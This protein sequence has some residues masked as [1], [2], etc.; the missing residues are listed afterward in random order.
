MKKLKFVRETSRASITDG[1][2]L[3]GYLELG[4]KNTS[5]MVAELE[6]YKDTV[7]GLETE[8]KTL[9]LE[10]QYYRKQN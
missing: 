10:L 3:A 9:D 6:Y 5:E 1:D 4:Q 7:Q 2:G 8:N